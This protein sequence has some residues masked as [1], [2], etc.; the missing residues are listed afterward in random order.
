MPSVIRVDRLS[1]QLRDIKIIA[2][3]LNNAEGSVLIEVGKTKVICNASVENSVP[4]F[5][6]GKGKG[7]VTAE[8]SMLPRS[9][10]TRMKRESIIGK[11]NGRTQEIQ[12][13]ISRSLRSSINL[14]KLGERQIIIDCDVIE[15]DGGTRTAAITGGFV[16]LSIAINKLLKNNKL[17]ENPIISNVAA[18]S[19]GIVNDQLLLDLDYVE[20]SNCDCD[21]NVIMNNDNKIVEIQGTSEGKTFSVDELLKLIN[22]AQQGINILFEKQENVL[23]KYIL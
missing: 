20:D 7:W 15:A 23:R 17:K 6:K 12:R 2:D 21:V 8:Y 5:M 22:L 14:N 1:N 19:V 9:T 16:A 4:S 10:Q 18:I 11:L 3:F 13:L